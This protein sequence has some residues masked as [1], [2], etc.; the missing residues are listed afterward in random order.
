MGVNAR[1]FDLLAG[2]CKLSSGLTTRERRP[3]LVAGYPDML[4]TDDIL[5]KHF[6]HHEFPLDPALADIHARHGEA[7]CATPRDP[8]PIFAALGYGP[9]AVVDLKRERGTEFSCDLN[10]PQNLGDYSLV[11]DHGTVEHC[12]NVA[13]AAKNLASAVALDGYIVQHLPMNFFNHG[14]YNFNP[15]WFTD[16]YRGNG[17]EILHLEG[18]TLPTDEPYEV[19]ERQNFVNAPEVSLLTMVARRREMRPIVYPTQAGA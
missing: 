2:Y 19:P 14:Y 7:F 3:M 13:Q 12:F 10:E 9:M 15:C 6:G 8:V 16:F 5:D 17:F 18:W 4:V 11:L 1:V